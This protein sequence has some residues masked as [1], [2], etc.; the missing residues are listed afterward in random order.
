VSGTITPETSWRRRLAENP[1]LQEQS[2]VEDEDNAAAII[3][4][5]YELFACSRAADNEGAAAEQPGMLKKLGSSISEAIGG[6]F[7]LKKKPPKSSIKLGSSDDIRFKETSSA[8]STVKRAVRNDAAA[9]P[10]DDISA[11]KPAETPSTCMTDCKARRGRAGKR[12][13][14]ASAG[15]V[16]GSGATPAQCSRTLTLWL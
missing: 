2:K 7:S 13:I 1:E 10:A 4:S 11:E 8:H 9:A 15:V 16:V 5:A 14:R 3:Q 12:N 6:Y